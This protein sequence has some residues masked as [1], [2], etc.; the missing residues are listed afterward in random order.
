MPRSVT[1]RGAF[2]LA[3]AAGLAA[4]VRPAAAA[5]GPKQALTLL[6]GAPPGSTTDR[7]ARGFAPFLERHSLP[8][9]TVTVLNLPGEGG[10]AAARAL[11]AAAPDGRTLALVATP[12]LLARAVERDEAALLDRLDFTAAVS[13]D[14][15]VLVAPPTAAAAGL[16]GLKA[17]AESASALGTPPPGTASHLAALALQEVVP[18]SPLVFPNAA[19]ARQAVMAGNLAVALLPVSEAAAA[20]RDGRLAGLAV[21]AE[22]R[23]A[24]LPEVPGFA[25]QGVRLH[26]ASHRGVA[27]PRGV[28][29]PAL[30]ALQAALR[31]AVADPEFVAQ[32]TANG[33][34][35][36]YLPQAEWAP[37]L[38]RLTGELLRRWEHEPWISP[39]G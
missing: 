16:A 23:L 15:V 1:R 4:V 26:L 32:A 35:P 36:R 17:L 5:G 30:T 10:L 19:A 3:A 39:R 24:A 2:G 38:R 6:V 28:P 12:T 11:V 22:R 18:F 8:R 21:T 27:L 31:A 13:E 37:E 9:S 29:A 7:W 34:A 33:Y 25:E 20:L 14:P